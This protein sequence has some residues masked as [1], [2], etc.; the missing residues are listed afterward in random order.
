MDKV[1]K[2]TA[3][4]LKNSFSIENILS[5][6]DNC[7][8]QRKLMR[9]NPFENNHVLFRE[10]LANHENAIQSDEKII[11]KDSKSNLDNF[12]DEDHETNSEAASD[13]GN[14]S[15]HSEN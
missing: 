3:I 10:N 5:R 1:E 2:P 11:I 9:Q 4:R 8:S 6:P 15:V 13:D 7:D 14:S 12:D